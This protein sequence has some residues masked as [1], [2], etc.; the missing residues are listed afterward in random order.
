MHSKKTLLIAQFLISATMAF[1]MTGYATALADGFAPGFV[2]LWLTRFIT[3]WPVAFVLSLLVGPL[4]FW[5]AA[6]LTQPRRWG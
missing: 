4:A 2:G 5:L 1:L 3:A 6:R